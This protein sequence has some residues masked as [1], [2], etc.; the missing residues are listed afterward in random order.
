M[1]IVS[2]II[3]IILFIIILV[4]LILV[5]EFG[6]F[7][8]AKKS[9][10]RVDEFG[11]GFPPRAFG[12]KFGGTLY[13]VNWLPI[14]GFVRIFGENP[15]DESINGPD[16]ERS[17]VHKPKRIQA[18]VLSA[19]ILFNILLAWFLFSIMFMVGMPGFI[20]EEKVNESYVNDVVFAVAGVMPESPAAKAGLMPGDE[21]VR[22]TAQDGDDI[23][24]IPAANTSE[25]LTPTSV[26]D[27]I[28]K[29]N[30]YDNG[31]DVTYIHAGQESEVNI[32]PKPGIIEGSEEQ[33][34]IGIAMGYLGRIQHNPFTAVSEGLKHTINVTALTAVGIVS[35]FASAFTF[36]ADLSEVAGPVG[37]VGL[38]GDAS[39]MGFVF[40]LNFTASI[41]ISL[42]I[43]NLLPFPALDG[44]RLFF[45]LIEAIKGSP[46]KPSVANTVNTL[47]FG[48]LIVLMIVITYSDIMRIISG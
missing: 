21:I 20:G 36:T 7:I 17:F 1:A 23:Y 10:I 16:K 15:D 26:T 43:I 31:I 42:A 38:V 29:S 11:V 5:H 24:M 2:F 4:A 18:L 9:G 22:I 37:I 8:T 41:S 45:L 47:G 27:F 33:H 34:A 14:G 12:K 13:S 44:G 28:S 48:F 25:V 30:I 19:G 6:H 32:L 46:I 40:L 39:A 3:T 35:F